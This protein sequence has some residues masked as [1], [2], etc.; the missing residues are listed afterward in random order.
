MFGLFKKPTKPPLT[1]PV[2]DLAR[3]SL[4]DLR[5]GQPVPTDS[6][7]H[8][9]FLP[10]PDEPGATRYHNP[11]SGLELT[12][13]DG[14]MDSIFLALRKFSGRLARD[15]QPLDIRHESTELEVATEFGEPYWKDVSDPLEVI[16]FHEFHS[17]EIEIQF[18]FP[19]MCQLEFI[20]ILS[21]GILADPA[22]RKSYGVTKP[23][24]P[25]TTP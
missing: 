2:V 8:P 16:D 24:P 25:S 17:G 15:G 19:D 13:K 7:Y 10:S 9:H 5:I 4:D 12:T 6:T 3:F 14:V 21:P 18:E 20:T 22:Q 1:S 23:W 11:R